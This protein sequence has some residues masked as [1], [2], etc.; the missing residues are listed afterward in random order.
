M[1]YSTND[2]VNNCVSSYQMIDELNDLQRELVE[3]KFR[4]QKVHCNLIFTMDPNIPIQIDQLQQKCESCK[5]S[6][7]QN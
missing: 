5:Q 1:D 4:L 7:S 2:N 3:L 6:N